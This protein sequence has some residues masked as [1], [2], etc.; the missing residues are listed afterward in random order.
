MKVEKLFKFVVH[1]LHDAEWMESRDNR[2][3]FFHQAF[4]AVRFFL[5]SDEIDPS[6]EQ[7]II[8]AWE[9]EYRPQFEKVI[10]G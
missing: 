3:V 1:C 10:W 2:K 7:L 8:D 5:E 4:G 9:R 6:V